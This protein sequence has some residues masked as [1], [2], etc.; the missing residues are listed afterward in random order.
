MFFSV[1]PASGGVMPNEEIFLTRAAPENRDELIPRFA[2]VAGV[3]RVDLSK[4]E[5]GAIV[6]RATSADVLFWWGQRKL[7]QKIFQRQEGDR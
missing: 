7:G 5:R 3:A 4:I 2:P 1:E 6:R